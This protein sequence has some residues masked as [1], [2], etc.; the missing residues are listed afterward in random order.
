MNNPETKETT[1]IAQEVRRPYVKPAFECERVFET[2]ALTCT[3]TEKG[4]SLLS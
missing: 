1:R 3:F 4:A 2:T